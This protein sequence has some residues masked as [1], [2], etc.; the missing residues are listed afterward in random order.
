MLFSSSCTPAPA[1]AAHSY[2][3]PA[4][5][6]TMP[7]TYNKAFVPLESNPQ[8]FNELAGLLGAPPSLRFEDVFALDD[9][10]LLPE[11]ILALVLVFPTTPT[12]ETRLT[13][14]GSGARDWMV[15]HDEEDEDAVWFKQTI[16]NAC[17]LNACGLYAILHALANGRAKDFLSEIFPNPRA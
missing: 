7:P 8:V 12:F 16:N 11:K 2:A 1:S 3:N 17:G 9:P 15:G 6:L 4:A 10:A 14:E 5:I 13:A